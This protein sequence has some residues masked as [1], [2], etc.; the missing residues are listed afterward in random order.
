MN[1]YAY[2]TSCVHAKGED[3]QEMVDLARKITWETFRKY[4]YWREVKSLFPDYSYRGENFDEQ[5]ILT[6][7]F[8]IKDDFAVSFW[9]SRYRGKPCYFISHSGIEYIWTKE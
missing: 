9:K 8:H 2:E 6:I 1:D 5:G 3:I 7:G 4:V